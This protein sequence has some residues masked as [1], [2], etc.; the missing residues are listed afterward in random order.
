MKRSRAASSDPTAPTTIKDVAAALGMSVATVSRALSQPELLREETR[1]RVLAAV[2]KLGYRPNLLARSLRRGRTHSILLV[3]PTLSPFFLEIYA[4]AEEAARRTKFSVL[5]GHSDDDAD[6][7][8]S[9]FDQVISGRAD[10]IILATAS[11][12]EAYASGKRALPPLV[13]VLER[14]QGHDQPVVRVDHRAGAAEATR[15]LIELGHRRIAHITGSRR[16]QSTAHRQAGYREALKAAGIGYSE[17]LVEE[18]DFSMESGQAAMK[19]L[20]ALGSPP[21]AVF[22]ANDEMAFGAMTEARA[23][24]YLVPQDLSVVGYDD[25]KTAAFYNPPLTTVNIPRH[26]LGRRAAHELIERLDGREL[27]NEILLPTRLIVRESTAPPR[28]GRS[29][30]RG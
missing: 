21:T 1:E 28:K 15:H 24:G 30:A 22:A 17:E 20:L 7:E 9:Y 16:P 23:R 19:A 8:E 10:G 25:Q 18:G 5:L 29:T 11:V 12:P 2:Q 26:E 4:G 13:T 14:L 6:R 3:V 27:A